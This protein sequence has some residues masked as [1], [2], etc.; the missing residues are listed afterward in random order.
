[1][2]GS[3]HVTEA[4]RAFIPKN[5]VRTTSINPMTCSLLSLPVANRS[6]L[7]FAWLKKLQFPL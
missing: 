7:R 5:R 1:M 2:R 6:Q 4:E 3:F